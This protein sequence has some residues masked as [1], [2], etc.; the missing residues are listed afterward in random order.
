[1]PISFMDLPGLLLFIVLNE[2]ASSEGWV[3][4][5]RQSAGAVLTILAFTAAD[6]N[7]PFLEHAG[8]S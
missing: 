6:E 7:L 1:V 5:L 2:R 8:P 4:G 3:P